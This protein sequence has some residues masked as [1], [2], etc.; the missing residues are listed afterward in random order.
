VVDDEEAI[1]NL[2]DKFLSKSGHKVKTLSNGADAIEL[3][4]KEEFDFAMPDV[5]VY[6]AIK[7]LNGL[8]KRPKVDIITGW[9]KK[10]N[11]TEEGI[12]VDF[13]IKKP[14][15]FSELRK[16]INNVLGTT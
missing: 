12:E 3:M 1:C 11:P 7:A 5:F 14:F 9:A 8:E 10:L 15:N 13:I 4:K 2:L 6:D 16:Q